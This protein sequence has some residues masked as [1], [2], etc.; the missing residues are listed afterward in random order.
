M[1]RNKLSN[2]IF[3]VSILSLLAILVLIV[4]GSYSNLLGQS[5]KIDATPGNFINP[6]LNISVM[7]EI[8][9]REDLTFDFATFLSTPSAVSPTP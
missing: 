2:Y 1:I 9:N 3:F 8:A 4:Q 7:E 6:D 5:A